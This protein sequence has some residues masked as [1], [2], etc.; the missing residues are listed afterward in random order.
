MFKRLI[1]LL[2]LVTMVSANMLAHAQQGDTPIYKDPTR[3]VADRV[4]DLLSRMTLDEK[5]GQ[6]TLVEKNSIKSPDIT[7]MGIGGLLSGGGGYPHPNTAVAWAQMVDGFQKQALS[8]RLG[9]PLLYGV[10]AIHGDNNLYGTVIFPQSIGLGAANDPA[11]VER[12]GRAT[13]DVTIATGIYWDYAPVVAVTQDI[14]WGRTFETYSENTALVSS[15]SSAMIRGLQGAKLSDPGSVLATP[16][17]FIGDG[18]TT[19]GSSATTGYK[20]DQGVTNVDEAT[21]RTIHLPPYIEAIKAGAQSIMVSYSSWGGMKM[22]AQHYLLTDVLKGE[23]GFTGFL[24]SDWG[25]L[26]QIPGQSVAIGIN[27][28]L[29]MI[30]VPTKYVEFITTLKAL[31]NSGD[32]PMSRIDDAVRRILTVKFEM[33]LFEHPLSD[34]SRLPDIG[35]DAQRALAREA[36]GKSMVLLQNNNGALP[37]SKNV[38]SILVAG[39][40]AN[41]IGMQSGGWT[42]EWQ[43]K[44]GA[45]TPGTTILQ[46]IQAAVA[47]NTVITYDPGAR[48]QIKADVGI[49]VIGEQPYAEGKGDSFDLALSPQDKTLV[50]NVRSRVTKLV[51]ILLSGRP[52]VIGPELNKSDAFVAAWLPGTEGEGVADVLFGIR[53]FTGKL[54]FTWPRTISQIPFDFKNLPTSGCAAPLFPFGYGLDTTSKGVV[55]DQCLPS[56]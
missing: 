49:V 53:P 38:L 45:I 27:A 25:A 36:V 12:I 3:P 20:L 55:S 52:M 43:G 2:A 7:P 22:S 11:L 29:D 4:T 18:G 28:G 41:D 19:W 17:H 1:T 34:P 30:M 9:I 14:R 35:S 44:L 13:A 26:D 6:M 37:L 56:T 40:G 10:D 33:G 15:L 54:S 24:V 21:L 48:S 46:G 5:I 32:V 42:I 8:S 50:D 39:Q 47:P 51:V 31:V 16:K 23:L